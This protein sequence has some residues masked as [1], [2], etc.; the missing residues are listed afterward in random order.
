M[1][2]YKHN[3]LL[4]FYTRSNAKA[5]MFSIRFTLTADQ[6]IT[7]HNHA[8][9]SR[10]T[11]HWRHTQPIRNEL[12]RWP[13]DGRA[14]D[15]QWALNHG[16]VH[17][18]WLDLNNNNKISLRSWGDVLYFINYCSWPHSREP[19]TRFIGGKTFK[20]CLENCYTSRSYIDWLAAW[21]AAGAWN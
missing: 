15:S 8:P 7:I 13:S 11:S 21:P 14:R 1:F 12:R 20:I 5:T 2:Y 17:M 18:W 16:D 9:T 4:N 19:G 10:M 6:P 3:V